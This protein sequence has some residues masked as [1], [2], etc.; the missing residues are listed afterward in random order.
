MDD[1]SRDELISLV[2]QHQAQLAE[3]NAKLAERDAVIAV[4]QEQLDAQREVLESL[5]NEV[6]LLKRALFGKR[7]ERFIPDPS[8][9]TLFESQWLGP[10]PDDENAS[11][12]DDQGEASSPKR[13]RRGKRGRIVIPE[14]LPR[15]EVVHPLREEDI[16]E[17]LRGRD[18][19]RRFRKRVGQYVEWVEASAYVVEEYVEVLAADN[20]DA[21][22][23]EMRAAARPP[24]ILDSYVGPGLLAGIA[25]ER[26]ADF[27][28]YYRVEERLGRVGLA[29]PRSTIARWMID[30]SQQLLPLIELIR[31]EVLASGVLCIDETP[32]K[33]LQ[34]GCPEAVTAYLWTTVGDAAHPYNAFYFTENRS[35]A[36]PERFLG[37]FSGVLVSDAYVCYES[38]QS[39]WSERMQ[40]ACCHAHARRKFEALEHLGSTPQTIQALAYFRQLFGLDDQTRGW[41]D[42]ARHEHRQQY[43]RPVLTAMKQWMDEQL[44]MLRPKHPLRGAIQYM[45]KRWESFARFLES[46][47]I[48]LE[49]NAAER[50]VKLPVIAKKN[51]LFF[52]STAGGEAAMV[53]YTL[54]SSCRRL[55]VDPSAYLRDVFTRLP[56]VSADKLVDFLPDRWLAAHPQHRL[57]IRE[58]EADDRSRRKRESRARRRR[59]LRSSLQGHRRVSEFQATDGS[60]KR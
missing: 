50:S 5:A 20:A 22:A 1:L 6:K 7:R 40:W 29:I 36:G 2:Q 45:T 35:R 32:V 3:S 24:R 4:Q 18:D 55:H 48:P 51:H 39:E 60:G 57:E 21:T 58:R 52:A 31:R 11:A 17:H 9:R 12:E 8:Q 30:L 25:T 37:D 56:Q 19:L 13:R 49:N 53:F 16:P 44:Q 34:P 38:L 54:T 33:L 43:S 27:L 42:A 26:F 15:K 41:T 28:P 46:G 23:T 47:A 10:E 59:A 14:S